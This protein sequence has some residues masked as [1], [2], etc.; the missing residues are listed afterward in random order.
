MP[1][2]TGHQRK[3]QAHA[4]VR[5]W[6]SN[7]T[8]LVHWRILEFKFNDYIFIHKIRELVPLLMQKYYWQGH[9]VCMI[10]PSP[11]VVIDPV[12]FDS[13][14]ECFENSTTAIGANLADRFWVGLLVYHPIN[15]DNPTKAKP[16]P[17]SMK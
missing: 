1:D 5:N 15:A 12:K 13:S 7:I 10:C 4:P 17:I 3:K 2:L 9:N 11:P 8:T 14:R 16:N 6:S